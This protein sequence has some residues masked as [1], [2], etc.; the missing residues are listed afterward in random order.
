MICWNGR[1]TGFIWL[2]VDGRHAYMLVS[3]GCRQLKLLYNCGVYIGH[4]I[5][6]TSKHTVTLGVR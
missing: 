3:M 1:K 4:G 5:K 2:I 6:P